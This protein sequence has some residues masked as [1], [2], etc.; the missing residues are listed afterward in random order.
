MFVKNFRFLKKLGLE[1][2][3]E[4]RSPLLAN[5][6]NKKFFLSF[7][8]RLDL[9]KLTHTKNNIFDKRSR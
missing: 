2:Y 3:K 6:Q 7:L 4:S 1:F 9:T 8:S 5:L